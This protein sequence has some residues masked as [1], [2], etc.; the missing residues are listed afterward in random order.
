MER[1]L[2]F[3]KTLIFAVALFI[4]LP[5]HAGETLS[6]SDGDVTLEGYLAR[7]EGVA[8]DS[9]APAILIVHQWKG[10]GAYERS[11]ADMLAALGYNAFVVDM[12]GKGVRP[13]TAEAAGAEASKYKGDPA[14]ARKR[15]Q[16]ALDYVRTLAGVDTGNIAVIGYCFGGT[17]ALEL[18]RSGADIKAA[19]SF[20]G[21]LS[22][23]APVTAPGTIKASVQVHHGAADKFVPPEEVR[24]FTAEMDEAGADWMLTFYSGAVH[25]FTEKEAGNDP[26]TGVA[27]N[28]K[29]DQRSWAAALD[30]LKSALKS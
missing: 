19:I 26:S 23:K 7:A 29:A 5:A 21:G 9:E 25:S 14:L 10:P 18:A 3:L 28:E 30:F 16:A 27:Y 15:L 8:D 12:Y 2:K 20:H 11:R 13:D 1:A 6:Y 22:S 4:A 24:Q 17:M